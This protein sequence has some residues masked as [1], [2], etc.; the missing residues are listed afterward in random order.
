MSTDPLLESL[1]A[2]VGAANV[3]V[4]PEDRI[5]YEVDWTRRFRGEARA[6][7]RPADTREVA[8]VVRACSAH[9][10]P[11][12]PQGG[13]TG[14]VGGSVPR[15]GEV[16]LSLR[17]LDAVESEDV[18]GGELVV[19]AGTTLEQVRGI[20][21]TQGW[22]VGV[23]LASRGSATIGGMVATNAG[24]AHAVRYGPMGHQ[25]I[26]VEA[27]LADGSTIG[28]VPALRKDNTGYH[29][30]AI[31]AG[32]EG[33]LAIVT[34][35]HLA[36]VP[37]LPERVVALCGLDD[38]A[39]AVRVAGAL[40]RRVESVLAL[41][42][43][44]AAGIDLV[45]AYAGLPAPMSTPWPAYLAVECGGPTGSAERQIDALAEVLGACPEVRATAVAHDVAGCGRLRAYRE[46]HAE[47]IAAEGIP[48]KLDVAVPLHRLSEFETAVRSRV[49]EVAPTARTFLFGHLGDGNLHV[50]V[51][52]PAYDDYAVD[53][54]VLVLA[55]SMG[56]SISAE[57][58]IG[59]AKRAALGLTRSPAE[60]EAMV[61]VKR[62]L[63]PAGILNPGVL[64]APTV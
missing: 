57:H 4:D 45:C 33:T 10:A 63:D 54:A 35:V 32:S 47:A 44:F 25:V 60:I 23:D 28:R 56:G 43:V 17:R 9:G 42:V 55:A 21:H 39:D 13:N 52:G 61:A 62:A 24:G 12:V 38:L 7:V 59:V 64:F 5:G 26:G 6:V 11:V 50:N 19:G 48:H 2:A 29:W 30:G 49:R 8:D 20:A 46:L 58:G 16:V 31:L 51:L 36:L 27:V 34:R 41:E 53:D 18:A 14:L 37:R 1:R 3:L 22:D 15:G 40:R